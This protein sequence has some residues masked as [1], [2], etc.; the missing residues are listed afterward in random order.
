MRENSNA[1]A[2]LGRATRSRVIKKPY[3]LLIYKDL[4][5][6]M[7]LAALISGRALYPKAPA[8]SALRF[9]TLSVFESFAF[10]T[11]KMKNPDYR[12][13]L[14]A[15]DEISRTDLLWALYPKPS[16]RFAGL[17]ISVCPLLKAALSP[18]PN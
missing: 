3:N 1:D 7:R 2:K 8:P 10:N 4:V 11:P 9:F 6:G 5:R 13:G 15:R 18:L 17:G 16:S 14:C 12:R